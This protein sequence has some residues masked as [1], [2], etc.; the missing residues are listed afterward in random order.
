MPKVSL[1]DFL[2]CTLLFLLHYTV[3][4]S[5]DPFSLQSGE[6]LEFSIQGASGEKYT[7]ASQYS[8]TIINGARY[9]RYVNSDK[10]AHWDVIADTNG[11]PLNIAYQTNGNTMNLS[12]DGLGKVTMDG[13]W[14]GKKTEQKGIFQRNVTLENA[15]ILRTMEFTIGAEREFTLLQTDKFPELSAYTMFFKVLGNET[16]KV[17]AGAYSCKKVLFSIRGWRGLFYKSYYYVSDDAYRHLVKMT[18]VPLGGWSELVKSSV[19]QR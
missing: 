3:S 2:R 5:A 14:N 8:D 9:F 10:Y 16:I 13:F 1:Y 7:S 12:F 19:K 6:R 4:V 17:A 18:N 15:F 11:S